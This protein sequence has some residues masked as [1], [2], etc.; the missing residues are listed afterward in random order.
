[1]E[2]RSSN[3]ILTTLVGTH[4]NRI[5]L[6]IEADLCSSF[7]EELEKLNVHANDYDGHRAIT[8]VTLTP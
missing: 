6:K 1:M 8:R 4:S 7:R 2:N 5:H 3:L